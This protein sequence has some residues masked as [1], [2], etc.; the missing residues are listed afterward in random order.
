[1]GR[2]YTAPRLRQKG[3]AMRRIGDRGNATAELALA[4]PSLV[5]LLMVALTAVNAVKLQL[6][7]V[8]AAREAARASARGDSGPA[9]GARAAPAGAAVTVTESGDTIVATV[10]AA[11]HPLGGRLPGFEVHATAVAAREP[12]ADP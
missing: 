8:D 4:V 9:A 1:M 11:V 2:A 10:R 7:C 12:E 3:A 6:E 5:L